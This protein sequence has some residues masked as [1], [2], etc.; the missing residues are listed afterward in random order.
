[1][2]HEADPRWAESDRYQNSFLLRPDEA[3][4]HALK[5]SEENGLPAISV[6]AAQGKFLHLVAKS[7][8]AKKILEVGTL[9]G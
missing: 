3:L 5:A 4:D 2:P 1:M 8:N 6:S 7:V 9:G